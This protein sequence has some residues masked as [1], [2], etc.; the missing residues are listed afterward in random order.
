[1][2]SNGSCIV[3]TLGIGREGERVCEKLRGRM[4]LA[5]KSKVTVD[6]FFFE[7]IAPPRHTVC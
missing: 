5:A 7:D 1:M 6:G 2:N 3:V 4:G